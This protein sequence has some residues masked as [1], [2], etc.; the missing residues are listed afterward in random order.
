MIDIYTRPLD[1]TYLRKFCDEDEAFVKEMIQT[2]LDKIP[3]EVAMLQKAI[4]SSDWD[5]AYKAIHGLKSSLHLAGLP[6]LQSSL[7]TLENN[8]SD[9]IELTQAKSASIKLV[10]IGKDAIAQLKKLSAT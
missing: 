4:N 3:E 5:K 1:M 9:R 6:H 7:Q 8:V 10:E 2:L